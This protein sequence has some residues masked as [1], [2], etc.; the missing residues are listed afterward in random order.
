MSGVRE[1]V[2]IGFRQKEWYRDG[3]TKQLK[4]KFLRGIGMKKGIDSNSLAGKPK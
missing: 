4:Q 2:N 3:E 1:V